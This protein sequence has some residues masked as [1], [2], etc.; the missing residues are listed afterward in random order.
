MKQSLLKLCLS[1]AAVML[2]G[3]NVS[4]QKTYFSPTMPET[5]EDYKDIKFYLAVSGYD[6]SNKQ[7]TVSLTVFDHANDYDFEVNLPVSGSKVDPTGATIESLMHDVFSLDVSSTEC[8]KNTKAFT[9][10]VT[11][12]SP[13]ILGI[14]ADFPQAQRVW[15][16][17]CYTF[18]GATLPVKVIDYN[19][20]AAANYPEEYNFKYVITRTT[21]TDGSVKIS[22]QAQ[23]LTG[24]TGT[25]AI[26]VAHNAWY[27][28][29][30]GFNN[31]HVTATHNIENPGSRI[32]LPSGSYVQLGNEKLPIATTANM[33]NGIFDISALKKLLNENTIESVEDAEHKAIFYLPAGTTM[34]IGHS[35]AVLNEAAKI[36]LD[37][38]GYTDSSV[39]SLNGALSY[40]KQESDKGNYYLLQALL[41]MFD[42][43]VYMVDEADSPSV[44]VQFGEPGAF[45]EAY[46]SKETPD[47]TL[48][49]PSQFEEILSEYPNAVG[50]VWSE[51]HFPSGVN[52]ATEENIAAVEAANVN[53]VVIDYKIGHGHYYECNNFV[54]VDWATG[55]QKTEDFYS[56]TDFVAVKL[57]YTRTHLLTGTGK[58]NSVCLPFAIEGDDVD[59]D[60]YVYADYNVNESHV[61]YNK[62]EDITEGIPCIVST[63]ATSWDINKQFA[64]VKA[65]PD[66]S[67]N[68]T[69]EFMKTNPG[70]GHWVLKDGDG[71]YFHGTS[72]AYKC[73]PFRAYLDLN[74]A[75][76]F[77]GTQDGSTTAK[78]FSIAFVDDATSISAVPSSNNSI[79]EIYS[80]S[81]A[82]LSSMQKGVNI[83]KMLDG[84]IRKVIVK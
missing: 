46:R 47:A 81:G 77:G 79:S 78:Q 17:H 6:A 44:T 20:Q 62:K 52:Y 34:T 54:L 61:Y 12:V 49:T 74:G 41:D 2:A 7:S 67:T 43:L 59:G 76:E 25:P 8:H 51:D 9:T 66:R 72:D 75:L 60:I 13:Q 18:N 68:M 5:S 10:G 23:T 73:W 82:K 32:V 39:I 64:N 84:S 27:L 55:I 42:N 48:Y 16:S 70:T 31:K 11:G 37:L 71:T 14:A 65:T 63:T 3:L 26:A 4:A 19:H 33:G 40:M 38:P 56:P 24:E 69:G 1:L 29:T 21:A 36:T 53:N 45:I 58:Y 15:L 22:G 30:K 80:L 57:N 35:Q 50:Y 83:V 28:I